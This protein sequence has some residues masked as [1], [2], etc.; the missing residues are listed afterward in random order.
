[1]TESTPDV[2]SACILPNLIAFLALTPQPAQSNH[3][4]V[5]KWRHAMPYCETIEI[6]AKPEI[7][8]SL[9]SDIRSWP[10]WD[11]EVSSVEIAEGLVSGAQGWL[12]PREGP[13]TKITIQDVVYPLQFV[14]V[15]QLIGCVIMFEHRLEATTVGTRVLHSL[16]FKGPTGFLFERLLGPVLSR[17]LPETLKGLKQAAE[18]IRIP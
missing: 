3:K 7:V 9:Y 2:K 5:Y 13:R 18:A 4:H 14:A 1:M 10:Q 11:R 12:Q 8:F 17:G 15:S 6:N 16:Y